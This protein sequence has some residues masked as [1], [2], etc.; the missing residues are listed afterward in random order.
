[1]G[2]DYALY[3]DLFKR[4]GEQPK[5]RAHLI[6]AIDIMKE[7]GADGWVARYEEELARL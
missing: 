3:A 1:M 4:K 6:K 5:A 2:R 7:C